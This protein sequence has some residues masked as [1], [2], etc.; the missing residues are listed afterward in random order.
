MIEEMFAILALKPAV[1]SLSGSAAAS[2]ISQYFT[3]VLLYIYIC[4]KGLLKETW[5]G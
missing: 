4:W 5:H 1:L 2:A 3:A